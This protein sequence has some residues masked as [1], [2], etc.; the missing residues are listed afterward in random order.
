MMLA[1]RPAI[2]RWKM[3]LWRPVI[4][5]TRIAEVNDVRVTPVR[6]PTIPHSIRRFV[7]FAETSSHPANNDP[8]PAPAPRAGAN[9]P[10]AAPVVKLSIVPII[11][12]MAA[13]QDPFLA[14]GKRDFG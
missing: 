13:L 12:S 5:S 9:I 1:T 7:L 2:I 11:L 14:G 3:M 4:S 8:T 6:K 10:P